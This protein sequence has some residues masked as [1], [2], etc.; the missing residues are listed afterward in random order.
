MLLSVILFGSRARGDHRSTFDVDLLGI[1]DEGPIKTEISSCGVSFYQYPLATL[2]AK[3]LAGDLF[4]LHLT[5]EGKQLHDTAEIFSRICESFCYKASYEN[6][7]REASIVNWFILER[8]NLLLSYAM[9]KRVVWG[10]RTILIARSAEKRTPAFSSSALADFASAPELR[11]AIDNRYSIEPGSLH[12]LCSMV[13]S[14][15]GFSHAGLS[16]PTGAAAQKELL[17]GMGGIAKLTAEGLPRKRG[18][19]A[20]EQLRADQFYL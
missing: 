14:S 15:F 12:K 18:K 8:P 3:A 6:E 20:G 7:I 16:W 5:S 17:S 10:L 13:T 11:S 2:R 19:V 4:V 1:S 9:R